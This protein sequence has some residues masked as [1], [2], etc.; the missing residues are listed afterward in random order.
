MM[1]KIIERSI[2]WTSGLQFPE[3]GKDHD[4]STGGLR[5]VHLRRV[6]G[7]TLHRL[8][9]VWLFSR[10]TWICVTHVCWVGSWTKQG[11]NTPWLSSN[12]CWLGKIPEDIHIYIHTY[13]FIF[14]YVHMIY[15]NFFSFQVV[16]Q[17]A[18]SKQRDHSSRTFLK[19]PQQ[20]NPRNPRCD[21]AM[22][23]NVENFPK[24]LA[25]FFIRWIL[26]PF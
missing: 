10:L 11:S 8:V 15:P 17:G 21:K 22:F 26:I 24:A 4:C 20:R 9:K 25:T 2:F 5:R 16:F 23:S 14:T 7:C 19:R 3:L 6:N 1:W 12:R 13:S 18:H